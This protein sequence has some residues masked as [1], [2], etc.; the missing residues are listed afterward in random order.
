MTQERA[1]GWFKRRQAINAQR[2]KEYNAY[3]TGADRRR[4]AELEAQVK[5][6]QSELDEARRDPGYQWS[7]RVDAERERQ[8]AHDGLRSNGRG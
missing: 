2:I 6:L 3:L 7:K 1:P 8:Y 5:A 4:I